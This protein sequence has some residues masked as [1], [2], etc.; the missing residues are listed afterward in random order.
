[1]A[2]RVFADEELARLREFPEIS[3]EE[4]LRYFTLTPADRAF[5]DPGRGRGPAER[6]GLSV[7]LCV[8][9][10]LGFVPDKV[11]AAPS[12]AVARLAEQLEVDAAQIRSYGKRAQTRTEHLRLA[13]QYLG[14]RPAGALELKELDAFL[15]ARAMEH[16]SPTLLFGLA[17]EYL[18]AARVIRRGP[19][20]VVRRVA[21][22]R[23]QAQR[24]TYDRMAHEFTPER[25]AQLDARMRDELAERGKA[26]EDRQALLDDLLAIITDPQIP[27]EEIGGLIRGEGIGWERLRAAIAQAKPR[28]PRDH[29][30]LAA[31][32]ASYSYLRQFTPAVLSAVRFAGGTAATELLIAVHMLRELNATG[33]R[34]VPEE[35]PTGFLPTKWPATWRRPARPAA[36]PPTDTIGSYLC[37][38]ACATG[39]AAAT[40]T[41]RGRDAMPIPPLI[42]SPRKRGS[43]TAPNSAAWSENPPIRPARWP[44]RRTSC[45]KRSASWRRCSPRAMARSAS[46]KAAIW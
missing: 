26:G 37:C 14:W 15:L 13:A 39:C 5:V 27:D 38:C 29:G 11:A 40:C 42:C 1:V 22:A 17:C 16:D 24:E 34:K 12:V 10:W 6:L 2:T 46:T 9:P 19:E 4:L 18:I 28:L 41:F 45:T 32:D 35:A 30:H 3:R 43:S 21:H 36:P 33:V 20:T 25:C 31:L 8:L 7:A 44:P 23:A